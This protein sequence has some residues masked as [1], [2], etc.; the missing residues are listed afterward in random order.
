[1]PVA[2]PL[3]LRTIIRASKSR[4]QPAAFGVSEPRRGFAY[5]QATGT[6][7]PVMWDVAF[8]FT[9]NEAALFQLWFTQ[10]IARGVDEF[11]LPIK[12][13]FGL[14]THTCRFLPGS[15]LDTSEEGELFSYRATIMARAQIIPADAIT[16][17][18]A[19]FS[20]TIPNQTV[21]SNVAFSLSL[22]SY[23]T[24]GVG[25]YT[26]SIVAGTLPPGLWLDPTT[27]VVSGTYVSDEPSVLYPGLV[28]RRTDLFGIS[29]DSNAVLFTAINFVPAPALATQTVANTAFG[30]SFGLTPPSGIVAGNLLLV[31]FTAYAGGSLPS[32]SSGWTVIDAQANAGG[33]GIR[34]ALIAK[35]ATGSDALTVSVSPG[36]NTWASYSYFRI[37]GCDSLS[38]ISH[39]WRETSSSSSSV[40]FDP[41][42]PPGGSLQRLWISAFAWQGTAGITVTTF[43]SGH[44]ST[45]QSTAASD[46]NRTVSASGVVVETS[47]S[48]TPGNATLSAAASSSQAWTIAIRG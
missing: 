36:S 18:S 25:P 3:S 14:L 44:V 17:Y 22:A 37:T 19:S 31:L 7:T 30:D 4:S 33:T 47:T 32:A 23:W 12:T 15:L 11:E 20:G 16:A 28:F 34:S 39:D 8:R 29:F 1:M 6:D 41:L 5:F 26:Y 38:K 24:A 46:T 45:Q 42:T 2:Y 27:G 10:D 43:P 13:E 48:K 35:I 40:V 9:Q 21:V